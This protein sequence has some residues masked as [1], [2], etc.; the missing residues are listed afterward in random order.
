MENLTLDEINI[1]KSDGG[2]SYKTL[3]P[4]AYQ[5]Q[6]TNI[7]LVESNFNGKSQKQLEFTAQLCDPKEEHYGR[8]LRFWASLTWNAGG[9]DYRPS[10]LFT[11]FKSIYRL[12]YPERKVEEIEKVDGAMIKDLIGKQLKLNVIEVDKGD[13]TYN[14]VDGFMPART[15]I[16]GFTPID[17][18]AVREAKSQQENAKMVENEKDEFDKFVEDLPFPV[19]NRKSNWSLPLSEDLPFPKA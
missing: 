18:D 4:D 1:K 10:K 13:K 3:V 16:K 6:I 14:K 5:F 2:G 11:I 15:V 17:W 7:A 8:Q 12:Y 9:G 19:G